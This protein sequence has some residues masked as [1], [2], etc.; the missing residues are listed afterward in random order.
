[1]IRKRLGRISAVITVGALL[2]ASAIAAG[3]AAAK[4]PGW[5]I[6]TVQNLPETV[7]QNAVAGYSFTIRNTGSS[8]ISSIYLTDS[9]VAAPAFISNSRGTT[10]TVR[11]RSPLL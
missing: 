6:D 8:N 1:V 11:R 2:G 4:T 9:V 10:C 7:G 3:P 5:T